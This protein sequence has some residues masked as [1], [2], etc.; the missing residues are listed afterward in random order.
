[1]FGD[2][3][4][5][6]C[7]ESPWVLWVGYVASKRRKI[8]AQKD[9]NERTKTPNKTETNGVGLQFLR[10]SAWFYFLLENCETNRPFHVVVA[11]EARRQISKHSV[12]AQL[13]NVKYRQNMHKNDSK[14]NYFEKSCPICKVY[15]EHITR[16]EAPFHSIQALVAHRQIF[17]KL[18]KIYKIS[19]YFFAVFITTSNLSDLF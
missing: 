10:K 9:R 1:M 11:R 13:A 15:S 19:V 14:L 12:Q 18:A 5:L 7:T 8:R 2:D 6:W 3:S 17:Y 16:Q 4:M